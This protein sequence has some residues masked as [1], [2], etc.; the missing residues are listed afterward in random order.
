M[1]QHSDLILKGLCAQ[2]ALFGMYALG[3]V[4]LGP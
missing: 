1:V 2:S 3:R 4:T